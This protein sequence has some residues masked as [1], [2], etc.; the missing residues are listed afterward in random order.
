MVLTSTISV[1]K[2]SYYT[3]LG[4]LKEHFNAASHIVKHYIA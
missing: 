3:D 1:K 4:A 2:N